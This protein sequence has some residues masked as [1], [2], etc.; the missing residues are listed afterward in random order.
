M[1]ALV[2]SHVLHVFSSVEPAQ[3]MREAGRVLRPG[4]ILIIST[5]RGSRHFWQHPENSRPYPPSSIR[6]YGSVQKDVSSPMW[7]ALPR[8]V[9][10]AIWYHRK[11]LVTLWAEGDPKRYTWAVRA[12]SLQ[13]ALGLVRPL[14][15]DA[16][17]MKL[18]KQ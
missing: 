4:G 2:L 10:E 1:D 6:R 13:Y 5:L 16:Y 8:F 11:P 3:F 7:A 14:S 17:T 15:Y 12:N 9:Q 18:R